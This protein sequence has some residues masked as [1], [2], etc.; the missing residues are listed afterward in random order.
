MGRVATHQ[1]CLP[2]APFYLA[3]NTPSDISSL[4]RNGLRSFPKKRWMMK[5]LFSL[6]MIKEEL[7]WGRLWTS[8]IIQLHL[9]PLEK[10][11]M[12]N[13]KFCSETIIISGLIPTQ[14]VHT[15]KKKPERCINIKKANKSLSKYKAEQMW[16]GIYQ[17]VSA[18]LAAETFFFY[19]SAAF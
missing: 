4:E 5:C 19:M 14:R 2:R 8:C 13:R 18:D 10:S 3:S 15:Q 12:Q 11:Q 6:E 1:I 7:L 17:T 16:Q 9:S